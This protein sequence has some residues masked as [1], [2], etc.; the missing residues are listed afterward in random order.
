MKAIRIIAIFVAVA[1]A[2]VLLFAWSG[3]YDVAAT[4]PHPDVTSRFIRLVVEQSV[5]RHAAD[6][7]VPELDD[8]EKV[9]NGFRSYQEMCVVCHSAPGVK[10]SQLSEGLYPPPPDLAQAANEWTSAELF[11]ITKRGIKASGMPAWGQTHTDEQLWEIVAFVKVLPAMPAHEYREA[12]EYL[13]GP[14]RAA[15]PSGTR[16]HHH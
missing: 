6:V 5:K 9:H 12:V 16:D 8:P 14:Q 1:A 11:V 13:A 3:L 2:G 15:Q 10:P 7:R 4:K